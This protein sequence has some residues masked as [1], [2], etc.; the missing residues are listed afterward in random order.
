MAWAGHGYTELLSLYLAHFVRVS[1]LDLYATVYVH[2][3]EQ[4]IKSLRVYCDNKT[5]G[6][7]WSGELRSLKEH[8]TGCDFTFVPCPNECKDEGGHTVKVQCKELQKHKLKCPRR[9]YKCRHCKEAGE[10]VERTTTHLQKCPSMRV[11]C[12]NSNCK[13]KIA[14]SKLTI[15]RQDCPFEQVPCKYARIGCNSRFPRKE[16][17]EHENDTEQHLR[18]AIDTVSELKM[19]Q[20]D[21]HTCVFILKNFEQ[22][23]VSNESVYSTPFYASPGDYK[24]CLLVYVNGCG[25]QKGTHISVFACLMRGENDDHLS[26]P[27]NGKICIELLNQLD[28]VNHYERHIHFSNDDAHTK[29]VHTH[30]AGQGYGSRAFCPHSGLGYD[31]GRNCQYL[32]DDRLHFRVRAEVHCPKPWLISTGGFVSN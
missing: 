9:Q 30:F 5:E 7:E 6:C 3:G 21:Q 26:W 25:D 8:L 22:L 19:K 27:F 29:R 23:R 20:V 31:A 18:I 13:E 32:K 11:S 10:Y 12:P 4:D 14:R 16:R 15:H 17:E 24:L 2:V 1:Q 28:D